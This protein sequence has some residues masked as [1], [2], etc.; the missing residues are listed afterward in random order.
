MR[1]FRCLM[2]KYWFNLKGVH[3]IAD[4]SFHECD[5][6]LHAQEV[7]DEIANRLIQLKPELLSGQH[8]IVVKDEN[9]REIYSAELDEASIRERRSH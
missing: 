6:A 2:P 9:N 4:R 3:F 1:D 7:A 5:D 8:R